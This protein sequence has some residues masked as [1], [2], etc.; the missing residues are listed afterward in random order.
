MDYLL[1]HDI[2]LKREDRVI[3][4]SIFE[5][6]D[7]FQVT[8]QGE[9]RK[10]GPYQYVQNL[11]LKDLIF[12]AG[13]FTDAAYPQRIEIASVIRRDTLTAQ[14]IRLSETIN[15]KDVSD[16]SLSSN[17]YILRPGDIITVRR[18]PGYLELRSVSA[19]VQV[20]F[21]GLYVLCTR[22]ERESDLLKRAG[23]L[24][25]QA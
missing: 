24:S 23:G 13:G 15:V 20:Q 21:P 14:D 4:S 8:V 10:P 17:N 22:S 16:L 1:K 6:K 25:P 18:L 19:L 5:L 7:P 9:V 2:S 3:I 11:S 12:E